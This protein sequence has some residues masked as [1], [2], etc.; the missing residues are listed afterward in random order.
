M[1]LFIAGH[2]GMVGRAILARVRDMEGVT[3]ITAARAD[4]D[5]RDAGAVAA[6]L[7]GTRP[8]RII[9]A[10]AKVGGIAANMADPAGMLT[11]NIAIA[12]SVAEAARQAGV[13][14]M[15][16][17]GSSAVY[18]PGAPQPLEEGALLSGPPDP[19]H[20]GY[21]M[22]KLTALAHAAACNGQYGSD[23]RTILPTNLYGPGDNFHPRNAHVLAALLLRFHEAARE[24]AREVTV[25]GSG[26]PRRE[27]LHVDDMARAA[28]FVLDMPRADF[29]A[30]TRGALPALNVGTGRDVS[31]AEVAEMLAEVTGFTGAIRFDRSK[32][33]GVARKLL[34]V[35]RLARAG[36]RAEISLGEGLAQTHD[37][38]KRQDR[39]R[40]AD[41]GLDSGGGIDS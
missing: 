34:D 36:W 26:A 22:A 15:L 16:H 35:G 18:P 23:F 41:S 2:R 37:W 1:R 11:D 17:I 8:D 28:L 19:G 30:A 20:M 7:R 40:G 4:L 14:R 5:L 31:I 21:A 29:A 3:P 24:G 6:F 32:P 12:L 33:D 10:A 13:E 39:L 25:W 9:L 38:L 27:F